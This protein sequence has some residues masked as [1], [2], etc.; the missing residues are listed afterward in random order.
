MRQN[1]ASMAAI[2]GQKEGRPDAWW[3]DH[4]FAEIAG[5]PGPIIGY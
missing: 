2:R 5:I 3:I 4:D 1:E